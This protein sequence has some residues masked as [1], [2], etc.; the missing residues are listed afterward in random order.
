MNFIVRSLR[1]YKTY[2]R[3]AIQ[4]KRRD[5]PLISLFCFVYVVFYD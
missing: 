4:R 3:S 2:W 5:F 1:R